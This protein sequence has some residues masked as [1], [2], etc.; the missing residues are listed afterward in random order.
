MTGKATGREA[1]SS[2]VD[3]GAGLRAHM[4]RRPV[5]ASGRE[6]GSTLLERAARK[7]SRGIG[8]LP[9]GA[10][11]AGQPLYYRREE[12][13]SE[14]APDA[15]KPGNRKQEDRNNKFVEQYFKDYM[16]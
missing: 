5:T 16:V 6:D 12:P 14:Q 13:P 1:V 7:G 11:A 15:A 10:F 3:E 2:H 8:P 9:L 4:T